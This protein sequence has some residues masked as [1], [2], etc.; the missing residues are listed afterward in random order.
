[1]ADIFVSY[2]RDDRAAV[3]PLV[4]LL[5]AEHFTVWWDPTIVP[6]ERFDR[7]IHRALDEASCIV[8]AWSHLSVDSHWVQDE[9][10]IGRDRGVLVPVSI[11]GVD[12]PLGF[13]QLQTANLADW[14]GRSDDPR[15]LHFL[16]GVRRI[17]AA[18][19]SAT[20]PPRHGDAGHAP[21]PIAAEKKHRPEI[22]HA[23]PGKTSSFWN[24]R[25]AAI[26]ASAIVAIAVAVGAAL[27][28]TNKQPEAS[29]PR[30][31]GPVPVERSFKDCEA[32]C[33]IMV[34][35]PTGSFLMGSPDAE[36]QRG[37]DE[38]PQRQV[39]ISRVLAVAKF[40][41]TF[42]EWDFCRSHGGCA[43]V[44]PNDSNWGRGRHPVVNVSWEEAKAYLTWLST[45]TGKT[46]RLLSEAEREYIARAGTVTPF[47]WGNSIS[48]R[49]ANYDASKKY[50]DEQPGLFRQETSP[51]DSFEPNPWGF[52][53]VHGNTWDWVED[54]YHDSYEGSP[55][56]NG[57][58]WTV[59]DCSRRVLR[60]GSWASQP[61]NLRS[62]A[63][64]KLP[65][66]THEP[67]Y[68]FRV[69]RTCDSGC[70]F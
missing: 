70:D 17:T 32:G 13:R 38:G 44:F 49:Q 21:G 63:R 25:T 29:I 41:V 35:V 9:A 42:E 1:M 4:R 2:K 64:W 8:V 18:S 15:I 62:A 24:V 60:G 22:H 28:F 51:V 47:S 39:T 48:W 57:S 12:P 37:N 53:Q 20:G 31:S 50:A 14:G 43:G 34:V 11:D 68:G 36:P 56:S 55:P 6:G 52:Y 10:G 7:V 46:Y 65:I 3:E 19:D 66:D 54:C 33:P 30:R 26:G 5:E 59:G 69:A 45:F 23:P 40:P 58:A 61:R 67:Y 27:F 16:A